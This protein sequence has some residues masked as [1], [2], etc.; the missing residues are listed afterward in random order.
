[1]SF[2]K[3]EHEVIYLKAS[4]DILDSIINR[5]LFEL[6]GNDPHSEI[7]FCRSTDQK[8]FYIMLLEF[9]IKTDPLMSGKQISCL[10]LLQKTKEDPNF[11]VGDSVSHLASATELFA[12]WLN[13]IAIIEDV[14]LPNTSIQVD[15][16]LKRSDVLKICGNISKHSF[17]RLTN[18]AKKIGR[19]LEKNSIDISGHDPL[20][21]L[22]DFYDRFHDDV[23]NYHA[24]N[25]AEMLNNIRW[26]IHE[27]LLPEFN[28]SYRKDQNDPDGL[29]YCYIY[30]QHINN[31][32]AKNCYWELMN[33]YVLRKPYVRK[34]ESTKW[35]K[36]RY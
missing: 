2:T 30:P 17:A 27:Y 25:I 4:V 34:F 22:S 35:L 14:W 13:K 3:Q 11:N 26:G 31:Q 32:F 7:R 33:N 36:L 23:L 9:F 21:F 1:M 8:Y 16:K 6:L 10:D 19:I 15:L 5:E 28:K 20:S 18:T 29:R 24:S 12:S